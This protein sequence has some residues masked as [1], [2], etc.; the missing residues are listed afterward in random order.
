MNDCS[1]VRSG[2]VTPNQPNTAIAKSIATAKARACQRHRFMAC[3]TRRRIASDIV[4]LRPDKAPV[5]SIEGAIELSSIC[6][7][8][9][10]LTRCGANESSEPCRLVALFGHDRSRW[11]CRLVGVKRT[12]RSCAL[13]SG[14]DPERTS[15]LSTCVRS[16]TEI[17][18][19][20]WRNTLSASPAL[21]KKAPDD[22]AEGLQ[23]CLGLAIILV[24]TPDKLYPSVVYHGVAPC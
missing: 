8:S 17:R 19:C 5:Q 23:N 4:S 9:C 11:R 13:W 1:A 14:N 2:V 7:S 15:G 12:S 16:R 3:Q 24:G 6:S 18:L 20:R 22:A 10:P 21:H